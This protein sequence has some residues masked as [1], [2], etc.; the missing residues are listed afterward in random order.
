[1]PHLLYVVG[2][3]NAGKT[4]TC[5]VLLP[6]LL[7]LGLRV[8]TLKYTEH[9]GFDWDQSGKDTFRHREAGSLVTGIFGTKIFAFSLNEPQATP[10]PFEEFVALHYRHID[11]VLVEGYRAGVGRRIEVCRPGYTD[12]A[13]TPQH[14]LLATYGARLFAYDLPHFDYGNEEQLAQLIVTHMASLA[15]VQS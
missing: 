11:L 13:I 3:K 1:M 4:R 9:D 2:C 5:E 6:P 14:D 8:G 7:R 12:R 10:P 15:E